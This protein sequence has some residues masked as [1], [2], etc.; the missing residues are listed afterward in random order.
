MGSPPHPLGGFPRALTIAGSD[1]GGGAGIQADLKVFFALGC[2][3]MSALTA[4]T[5]Q[6]TVAVTG[7]QEVAEEF[8]VAQIDAVVSDI[9]VDAAKTGM[10]ASS[11]IVEAVAK[12]IEAHRL[13]RLVVDPVFIS[14]HKDKL[15]ADEAISALRERLIPLATLITPN[16]HEAGGLLG[17]SI[18]TLEE[19]KEAARALHDLGPKAVL[20]KGGHL[21]GD[22]ATDVYFDGTDL[23]EI[24]GPRFD[25]QDT[26]GTGC[27]IS[28]AIAARLAHG[29]ELLEAVRFGKRFVTGAIEHSLRIGKGYGPVNPGWELLA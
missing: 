8:V 10:L 5:A 12:S 20:V 26:H 23:V 29:D 16:L 17:T 21:P 27:V 15:L 22:R 28:A 1:S 25:T 18:G 13:E 9:G 3:G 2:H 19:M 4:L 11:G 6:N 24:D 14:K 7:I